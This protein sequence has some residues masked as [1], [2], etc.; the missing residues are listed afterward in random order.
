MAGTE[1]TTYTHWNSGK[2]DVDD[3]DGDQAIRPASKA[4]FGSLA[5]GELSTSRIFCDNRPQLAITYR[6]SG[7]EV[8]RIPLHRF[9][10]ATKDSTTDWSD[11]EYLDRGS[12]WNLTFFLDEN[13]Q[14]YNVTIIVNGYVVRVNEIEFD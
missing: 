5:F 4:S 1:A 11:Q 7:K 14:W 9:L 10:A 6:A 12:H 13:M 2:V 8:A 3:V